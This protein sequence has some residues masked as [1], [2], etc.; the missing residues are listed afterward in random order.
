M[1]LLQ[2]HKTVSLDHLDFKSIRNSVIAGYAAGVSGVVVGHPVDS[3]K[4]WAQTSKDEVSSPANRNNKN[5]NPTSRKSKKKVSLFE[6]GKSLARGRA[7]S[8][9]SSSVLP[10]SRATSTNSSS[11]VLQNAWAKTRR[12]YQGMA[13]PLLTIG[14]LNSVK[15][16]TY[17]STRR[18]LYTKEHPETIGTSQYMYKDSLRNISIAAVVSGSVLSVLMS[19]MLLVKTKQQT[20]NIPF[21][22]AIMESIT[23]TSNRS[24][25]RKF[26]SKRLFTGFAPHFFCETGGKII[27]FSVYES[28]KRYFKE[29]NPIQSTNTLSQRI[30]ASI[31]AGSATWSIIF[32]FDSIRSRMYA[33]ETASG[34]RRT[35]WEMTRHMYHSGGGWKVFY[36]GYWSWLARSGPITA[37]VLP[38]YD[39]T[40]ETLNSHEW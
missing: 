29:Q 39:I 4:V 16:A 8:T 28:T 6:T 1:S 9:F 3:V 25:E 40:M 34:V 12:L 5:K 27:Y 21:K 15:F 35:T 19:P 22:Q 33:Q 18:A 10:D 31:A 13:G 36:R 7:M 30:V 26:T 17:D 14:L 23:S 37:V 24:G 38:V 11:A 20:Q 2:H 32:P